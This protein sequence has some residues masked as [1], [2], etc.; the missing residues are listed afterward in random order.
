MD[1]RER[2]ARALW[3]R[4]YPSSD[5]EPGE[6]LC[7]FGADADAILSTIDAAGCAIAP[8]EPTKE[9]WNQAENASFFADAAYEAGD[10]ETLKDAH[11]FP[12][13]R[14]WN[15]VVMYRAMIAARPK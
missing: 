14:I 5:P 10:P 3:E 9:M 8:V 13:A 6:A 2:L 11:N 7:A 1:W 12:T 15:G 4:H